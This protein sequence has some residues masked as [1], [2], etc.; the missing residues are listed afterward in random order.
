MKSAYNERFLFDDPL[1]KWSVCRSTRSRV[2]KLKTSTATG[3]LS[4]ACSSVQED[5]GWT[6]TG[7][8]GVTA[9]QDEGF[10]CDYEA[11]DLTSSS[12]SVNQRGLEDQAGLSITHIA[13]TADNPN[14]T[15]YLNFMD[16]PQTLEYSDL[17]T[18]LPF[19]HEMPLD[20]E[21]DGETAEINLDE[22]MT[23]RHDNSSH[24]ENKLYR[25][26][27]ITTAS[28]SILLMKFIMK[29]RITQEALTDLLKILQ[30]HCPSPNSLP[31]TV[32]YFK[33]Q[34]RDFQ[35][36]ISYHYFCSKCF[37]EVST[38]SEVCNN[39][40]CN[41][42]LTEAHSKSS[43]IEVP[44]DLQLKCIL[45]RKDI[46]YTLSYCIQDYRSALYIL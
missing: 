19:S 46:S 20:A 5:F 33:K 35:Y 32:Y 8:E 37:A 29:H 9:K 18:P 45:E 23:E 15:N 21:E 6:F 11:T 44:I 41:S 2:K 31:S 27:P 34:F 13:E 36:P 12:P 43:F 24:H 30:L 25:G 28:S 14:H 1:S 42:T 26:A 17:I 38:E 4:A 39:S 40:Y 22:T 16:H 3:D 10:T 7:E